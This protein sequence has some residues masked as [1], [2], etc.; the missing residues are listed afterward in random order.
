MPE[1]EATAGA[2]DPDINPAIQYAPP[3]VNAEVN[4]YRDLR[5]EQFPNWYALQST[6]FTLPEGQRQ[7]FL[8]QFPELEQYWDWNRGYKAE[9]PAVEQFT[10]SMQA[11]ADQGQQ[12]DYSFF[13]DFSPATMSGLI[14]WVYAGQALGA[15]ARADMQMVWEDAGKPG[16]DFESF[17]SEIVYGALA[18]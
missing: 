13:Q 11:Q 14:G 10:T 4:T 16:G 3:E 17:L 18:P 12:I 15:G 5:T 7:G 8:Q 9:H 2:L 6:Y 1:T